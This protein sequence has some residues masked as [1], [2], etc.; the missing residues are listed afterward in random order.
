[1]IAIGVVV[2]LAFVLGFMEPANKKATRD[3]IF[4]EVQE[5][6]ELLGGDDSS[7]RDCIIRLDS[8]LGKS[9][10]YAGFR[11]E[12][13][14]KMLISAKSMFDKKLYNEIWEAHKLRNKMVHEN[15]VQSGGEVRSAVKYF[16]MGIRKLLR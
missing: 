12:T 16:K 10:K 8:L 13:L 5:C 15:Y 6:G 11:E 2:L 4:M 9:L 1:M 7:Q 14:G 3:Q